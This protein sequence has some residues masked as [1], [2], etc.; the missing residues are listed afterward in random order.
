MIAIFEQVFIL[1]IFCL[2]G[3][4][5]SKVKLVDPSHSKTLSVLLTYV[6]LPCV[7]FNT[8]SAQFTPAYL[9]DKGPLILVSTGLISVVVLVAK[10][11]NRFLTKEPYEK[12]VNEYSMSMANIAYMGYPLA[13]GVFGSA[14]LL[15]CMMFALPMTIYIGTVGFNMLTAGKE[16]K[17]LLK[18]IFT[19]SLIGILIGCAVGISGIKLP[20]V[21]YEISQKAGACMAPASMLITGMTISCFSIKELLKNKTVYVICAVRLLLAPLLVFGLLKLF[22]L[23]FALTAGVVLYAMP[24]GMNTIV[25]PQLVGKDCRL[26]AATVLVSTALSMLTI[27]LCLYFLLL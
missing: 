1:I 24:C 7:S 26:G 9:L 8:F 2:A 5:L 21:I 11:I 20:D 13:E 22:G 10:L 25:Y 23:E 17:S 16:K 6:F 3:Y 12:A 18:K 14:V 15:D 19:P 4:V 27:P